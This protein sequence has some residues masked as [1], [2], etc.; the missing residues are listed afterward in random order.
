MVCA[1]RTPADLMHRMSSDT[2]SSSGETSRR[3][4]SRTVASGTRSRLESSKREMNAAPM[5]RFARLATMASP[6]VDM[7]SACGG[8]R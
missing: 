7:S 5:P 4:P 6:S 2:P 3:A 1:A 8:D